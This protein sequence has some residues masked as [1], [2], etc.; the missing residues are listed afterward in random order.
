MYHYHSYSLL[1]CLRGLG[2]YLVSSGLALP[3]PGYPD[4]GDT[5]IV[6]GSS[7]T[8]GVRVD[9]IENSLRRPPSLLSSSY[10]QGGRGVKLPRVAVLWNYTFI[11]HSLCDA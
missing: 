6:W 9:R 11:P 2:S 5:E 8:V 4:T 7:V 3:S 10:G 1:T